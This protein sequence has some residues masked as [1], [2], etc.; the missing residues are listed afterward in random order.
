MRNLLLTILFIFSLSYSSYSQKITQAFMYQMFSDSCEDGKIFV[1]ELSDVENK[2]HK[3]VHY[4]CNGEMIDLD[5]TDSSSN[6]VT[7]TMSC[8]LLEGND[9][10]TSFVFGIFSKVQSKYLIYI[11]YNLE[12]KKVVVKDAIVSSA[13]E[14]FSNNELTFSI[15]DDF[16][17]IY[18]PNNEHVN[19]ISFYDFSGNQIPALFSESSDNTFSF[20][21]NKFPKIFLATYVINKQRKSI[22]II[23]LK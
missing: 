14:C 11:Y 2:Y 7:N 22:K 16:L 17:N 4:G 23:N 15:S 5:V 6:I 21:I 3:F 10:D 18:N 9:S 20:N 8:R 13:E 19:N 1:L 12:L